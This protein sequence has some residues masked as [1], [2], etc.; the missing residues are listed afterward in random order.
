MKLKADYEEAN[1]FKYDWVLILRFDLVIL[2]KIE[3]LD[4]DP[5]N[6][7]ICYEPHWPDI[8]AC[9][10]VHDIIFLCNSSLA[11]KY[12]MIAEEIRQGQYTNILYA[13]HMIAYRKLLQI[14][15]GT[16]NIRYFCKRFVD[17]DIYRFVVDPDQNELG[18]QYGG[19]ETYQRMRALLGEI[20]G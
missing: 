18:K 19:L 13:A 1:Q 15:P 6:V 16:I 12:G 5:K 4:L 9:G 17:M 8:T 7:Y 3:F 10:M 11:D 14:L 20:N 2:N